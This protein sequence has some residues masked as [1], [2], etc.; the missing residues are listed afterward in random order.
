MNNLWKIVH[1]FRFLSVFVS[2]FEFPAGIKVPKKWK[3]GM[4][5]CIGTYLRLDDDIINKP[6]M[7]WI[8]VK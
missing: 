6:T 4:E 7:S 2:S 3:H 5:L 8:Q 1:F